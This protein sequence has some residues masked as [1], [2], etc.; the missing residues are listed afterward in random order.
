MPYGLLRLPTRQ[1]FIRL[2]AFPTSLAEV[3]EGL[4]ITGVM[5]E[6]ELVPYFT[7]IR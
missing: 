4:S 6:E 2:D 5:R 3:P 1:G 7:Q